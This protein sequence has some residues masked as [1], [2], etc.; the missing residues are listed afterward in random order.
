MSVR[1][2]IPWGRNNGHQ[3][4]S[5]LRED[6]HDPFLSLHRE[7]NRL[8]DDAFRSFG[9]GLPSLRGASGFG[10]GWPS[11]EI[12]DTDKDIKVTAEVPG[13]EEKDIEV[14]LDDGVLTLKGEKRSETED[15]EKQFSERY[16]GRFERRIPLATEVKEDQVD[17]TFKNG[18]LTVTL[19]KS[20]K[21]QSQVRRIAIRT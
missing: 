12:S 18:V 5:L 16:Y 2:L 21:A 3:V 10:A 9:S 1:D 17:A 4:P 15:K 13:L 14:I 8:F 11:V 19:P 6:D 7:V 20:E